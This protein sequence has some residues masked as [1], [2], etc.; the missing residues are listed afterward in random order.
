MTTTC[1]GTYVVTQADLDRG[2]DIVNEVLVR[3]AGVAE[4]TRRVSTSVLQNRA[5]RITKQASVNEVDNA[6]D[7]IVYTI[8]VVNVGN[9]RLDQL[10][11]VD[12]RVPAL[13]CVPVT[14][15]GSLAPQQE[16]RCTAT[17]ITTQADVNAGV[18]LPNTATARA[19]R[20]TEVTAVATVNVRQNAMFTA[21]KTVDRTSVNLAGTVLN[22]VIN[23]TNTGN[24]DLRAL[25]VVDPLLDANTLRCDP[26][27]LGATLTVA[28]RFTLCTGRY[29][30][31]QSDINAGTAL[32]NV[33]QV[34][35]AQAGPQF[36]E[37]TTTVQRSPAVSIRKDASRTSVSAAG[38]RIDYTI[39][40]IATGNVDLDN[41]QVDDALIDANAN[42]VRCTLD[43]R[44]FSEGSTLPTL[45][46]LVCTGSFTVP[47][48]SFNN[49]TLRDVVNV[50]GVTT[51]QTQ[52][53]ADDATTTIVRTPRL[54]I[55]KA[56]SVASVDAAG[57]QIVYTIVVGN[58]GNVDAA[59]LQVS[60]AQLP[61]LTCQPVPVGS[62]LVVGA[63]TTC[64]G[65]R[66]V[67]QAEVNAGA[68]L[69]NTAS[70][71]SQQTPTPVT[72]TATVAVTQRPRLSITK[73]ADRTSVNAAGQNVVYTI[74]L[75]NDGNTDLS[76][77]RLSDS[78]I[79]SADL[80]CQPVALGGTLTVAA[81][82]TTCTGAYRVTQDDV[83]AGAT[84]R[85]VAIAQASGVDPVSAQ[86]DVAVVR[87]LSFTVD[88][89]VDTEVATAAGQRL[90]Y[91]VSVRATGNADMPNFQVDDPLLAASLTCTLTPGQTLR[92]SSPLVTCDGEYVV[93]QADMNRGT[94]IVNVV[95][96]R[97][98]GVEAKSAQATT[99][100]LQRPALRISKT[101]DRTVVSRL[102]EVIAYRI[103]VENV[104][105]VDA[106]G[107]VVQDTR[108]SGLSCADVALGGTLRVGNSTTCSGSYAV[109]QADLNAGVALVN[110]A[111]A[112]SDQ[113][114][115]VTALHNVNVE[116]TAMFNVTKT[117]SLASVSRAGTVV[118][119][120]ISILNTGTEDLRTLAITDPLIA[121]DLRCSPVAPGGT[122]PVAN[123]RTTCTGTYT[124]T[125]DDMDAGDSIVN[126]ASVS[127]AQTGVQNAR[128]TVAVAR[129]PS[130]TI[131]KTA[132]RGTVLAAGETIS[133]SITISNTGN[134]RLRAL[135]V[136]RGRNAR[137][138]LH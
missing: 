120:T 10:A 93:T 105:T 27:A 13:S 73:R 78:L 21:V 86:A 3:F 99:T 58:P 17:Y 134:T 69:V 5:L 90:R 59:Q 92:L 57:Q 2:D 22:Y 64:V 98:Q 47:Q 42:D 30:V 24:E 39:T 122:L 16:T 114:T 129:A 20:T 44:P 66:T 100:V 12:S 46:T 126:T 6:G 137:V 63:T 80:S 19:S 51:T 74:V 38:E 77:L 97:F 131:L 15:N 111:T 45:R 55:S 54:A 50:A 34:S 113:T 83:N 41:V 84:L 62:T 133:Y 43:G 28:A 82:S 7:P 67:T 4:Q 53:V 8:V 72:A 87:T 109:T 112:D 35:F 23:I 85:N 123:P 14:Q 130:F 32:R 79:R 75:T 40:I 25:S 37:V 36:P 115:P 125:Q 31:S 118:Q 11:V 68:N 29:T 9:V 135:Q 71:R 108:V 106:T 132:D 107:L 60:D 136:R 117:A 33:A 110:T 101:A 56:A 61:A 102:G 94:P 104:G 52:R 65:T 49:A 70:A 127:F 119:W 116:A 138:Q 88:K 18:P 1:R 91:R 81:R 89:T 26:V 48:A 124:V 96:V 95:T 121:S 128:A 103:V 76:N